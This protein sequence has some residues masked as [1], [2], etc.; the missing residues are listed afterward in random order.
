MVGKEFVYM[1]VIII[2][3]MS[4]LGKSTLSQKLT[5]MLPN[6]INMSLDAYKERWWDEFGFDSINQRKHLAEE[7][8]NEYISDIRQIIM[9]RTY[10]YVL[11]DYVFANS[12]ESVIGAVNN[13]AENYNNVEITTIY[14][15]PEN[16]EKHKKVWEE[17]SRDFAIRHAGH[18]ATTY[19]NGT[20]AGYTN[21]YEQ[22]I[23][24]HRL[25]TSGPT[26]DVGVKFEPQYELSKNIE[27]IIN[28]ISQKSIEME[29]SDDEEEFEL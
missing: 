29:H 20:G 14:L 3:G 1:K 13:M 10:D 26:M 27:E 7:A 4:C 2:Q 5:E 22:K 15:Y 8:T 12:Y 19:H 11:L 28:F 21:N 16:I 17:R 6:C 18:G 25:I 23:F 9:E 24:L